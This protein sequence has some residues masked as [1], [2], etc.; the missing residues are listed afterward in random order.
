MVTASHSSLQ[1]EQ[2]FMKHVHRNC[3]PLATQSLSYLSSSPPPHSLFM[4]FPTSFKPP[5]SI[6]EHS[7]TNNHPPPLHMPKLSQ[8]LINTASNGAIARN[9][10]LCHFFYTPIT[11]M[12][13]SNLIICISILSTKCKQSNFAAH[14]SQPHDIML[15]TT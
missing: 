2:T 7:S 4:V 13:H 8:S 10:L 1:Y 3:H 12:P 9:P 14:I 6:F 11:F 5:T 15:L